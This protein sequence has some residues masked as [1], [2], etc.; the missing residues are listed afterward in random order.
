MAAAL[1]WEPLLLAA[2]IISVTLC[3][4]Q[5]HVGVIREMEHVLG[6]HHRGEEL[7]ELNSPAV[8]R[9][10]GEAGIRQARELRSFRHDR[11][12][13]IPTLRPFTRLSADEHDVE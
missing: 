7:A 11:S 13:S 10:E 5:D 8:G 2:C 1:R 4:G 12:F 6:G 9:R 3:L